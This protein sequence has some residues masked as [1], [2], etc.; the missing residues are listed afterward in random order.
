M[1]QWGKLVGLRSCEFHYS[2]ALWNECLWIITLLSLSR[3]LLFCNSFL[4]VDICTHTHISIKL[5]VQAYILTFE[6]SLSWECNSFW[7]FYESKF[8]NLHTHPQFSSTATPIF[9]VYFL[10]ILPGVYFI[11]FFICMLVLVWSKMST[12]L[13]ISF[14]MLTRIH[15]DAGKYW[16]MLDDC[17]EMR[18]WNL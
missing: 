4:W 6:L 9:P 18:R 3:S 13:H 8:D 16:S 2:C 7:W 14:V 1:A 10:S 11:K 15:V 17:D 5:H 12:E